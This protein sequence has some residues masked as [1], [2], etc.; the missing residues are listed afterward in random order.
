MDSCQLKILCNRPWQD[1]DM[2]LLSALVALFMIQKLGKVY[3]GH[4]S[5]PQ[6]F[7]QI[8]S[9]PPKAGIRLSSAT[10][11]VH[12]QLHAGVRLRQSQSFSGH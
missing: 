12:L 5:L 4:R 3:A 11:L 9:L 6:C 1:T 10:L 7:H 2:P 8:L